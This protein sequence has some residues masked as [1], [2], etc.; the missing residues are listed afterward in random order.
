MHR[1]LNEKSGFSGAV[2][3]GAGLDGDMYMQSLQ[4][5]LMLMTSWRSLGQKRDW[6][7]L[8][9]MV[10]TPACPAWR[11]SRTSWRR[12]DGPVVALDDPFSLHEVASVGEVRHQLLG[13]VR[14][15]FG[16]PGSD[17]LDELLADGGSL[18]GIHESGPGD[19]GHALVSCVGGD[20]GCGGFPGY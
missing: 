15:V 10:V 5:A 17:E 3:G 16:E 6:V 8:V 9:S 14:P 7:A 4:C 19:R 11:I 20:D 1:W 18:S 2:G 12:Y 13:P